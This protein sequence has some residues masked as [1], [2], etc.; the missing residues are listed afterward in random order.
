MNSIRT[1]LI[2]LLISSTSFCIAQNEKDLDISHAP[3]SFISNSSGDFEVKVNYVSPSID[4]EQVVWGGIIPYNQDWPQNINHAFKITFNRPVQIG[5]DQENR[6]DKGTYYIQINPS[7]K[8]WTYIFKNEDEQIVLKYTTFKI[9]S[10]EQQD[11][12]LVFLDEPEPSNGMLIMNIKWGKV[13][14]SLFLYPL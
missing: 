2:L 1:I 8:K 14:G 6:L 9:Y 10:I 13:V 12:M 7:E 11:R 3:M 4:K 5:Y